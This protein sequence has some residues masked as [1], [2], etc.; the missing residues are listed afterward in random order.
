[1]ASGTE[2]EIDEV[3]EEVEHI[4]TRVAAKMWQTKKELKSVV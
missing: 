1:M 3:V 2:S 4:T